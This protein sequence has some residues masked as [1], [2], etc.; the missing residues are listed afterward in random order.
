MFLLETAAAVGLATSILNVKRG[1][2]FLESGGGHCYHR[3]ETSASS[4]HPV[5]REVADSP[6]FCV[7]QTPMGPFVASN[8][9]PIMDSYLQLISLLSTT[10]ALRPTE[11]VTFRVREV[12]LSSSVLNLTPERIVLSSDGGA[13]VQFVRSHAYADLEFFNCGGV[14][15]VVKLNGEEPELWEPDWENP[16]EIEE[17]LFRL[18]KALLPHGSN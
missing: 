14:L 16:A 11:Q 5:F 12:L 9:L 7:H 8:E 18:S 3:Y 13:V 10:D 1:G 6:N 4:G 15:G 2:A 17:S